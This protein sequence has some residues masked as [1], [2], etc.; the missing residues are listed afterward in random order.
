MPNLPLV[1]ITAA[2]L[3]GAPAFASPSPA[4]GAIPAK[5]VS[6]PAVREGLVALAERGQTLDRVLRR[7]GG[8][9]GSFHRAR[10]DV[11]WER[12]TI[13]ARD[14]SRQ[15]MLA[16]VAELLGYSWVREAGEKTSTWVLQPSRMIR[17]RER[18]LRLETLER[19]AAPL[20]RMTDHL[21][22]P[23]E[24]YENLL[25]EYH[26]TQRQPDDPLLRYPNLH[27]L[28]RTPQR[29]AIALLQTLSPEQRLTLLSTQKH[30]MRWS[31][32]TP[33]QRELAL[34]LAEDIG[35]TRVR[36]SPRIGETEEDSLDW[37]RRFGLVLGI[38]MHPVTGAVTAYTYG[39]GGAEAYAA[40]LPS[41][42]LGPE[43][44]PVR[45]RP[46]TRRSRTAPVYPDLVRRRFPPAMRRDNLKGLVWS[47]VVEKLAD[48]LDTPLY[49]D[50]YVAMPRP[51]ER[52]GRPLPE[53]EKLDLPAGLDALCNHYGYLWWY[54]RG[55]I[56]FRSRTWFLER[57]YLVP[58]ATLDLV[59]K[60]LLANGQFDTS[61]LKA[62][63]KLSSHQLIGLNAL[64]GTANGALTLGD[65]ARRE[66]GNRMGRRDARLAHG[67]LQA[68]A[69]LLKGQQ[70]KVLTPGGLPVAEMT[71]EQ[72]ESFLTFLALHYGPDMVLAPE[73]LSLRAAW[74]VQ[75]VSQPGR[76]RLL[77]DLVFSCRD[78]KPGEA[79]VA[80][81]LSF[82][83]AVAE[84]AERPR[85]GAPHAVG[86]IQYQGR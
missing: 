57:E 28:A 70:E 4:A 71:A 9:E 58:P 54:A 16:D 14:R 8:K 75:R 55:A 39:E 63:S 12:I 48:H 59:G 56:F 66:Y 24:Y 61:T 78:P 32:M 67:Y 45:G 40:T 82:S 15:D 49:S 20:F 83:I 79:A 53:I 5:R 2:C 41:A 86:V 17:R 74:K 35:R 51:E 52:G 29:A 30:L 18:Q 3:P 73:E 19:G 23:I 64:A 50:D 13:F 44:L 1:L 43:V 65:G 25:Q 22:R 42:A 27:N 26:R 36:F 77:A 34:L 81:R 11:G 33:E 80:E 68:Y 85:G 84:N 6:K 69:S 38:G 72:R 47:Q 10:P 31:E 46:Y 62:L 76:T 7:L 37:L 21:E 60:Q